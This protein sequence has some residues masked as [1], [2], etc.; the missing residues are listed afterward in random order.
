MLDRAKDVLRAGVDGLLHGI[1]DKP[2]DRELIDLIIRNRAVYV[3]T[4]SMYEAV[5]DIASW[6]KRQS[7]YD[8]R[9]ILFPLSDTFAAADLRPATPSRCSTTPPLPGAVCR[10]ESESQGGVRRR[11]AGRHG[12]RFGLPWRPDGGFEPAGAGADGRGRP[13]AGCGPSGGNDQRRADDR[14]RQGRGSIE[15]G[16]WRISSCSTR[17][18]WKTFA[19]PAAFT[20]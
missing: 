8:E 14:A 12:N 9:G 19:T 10:S 1:V 18:R 15:P 16:R 20:A 7:A 5:G 17:T 4:M 3:P 11:G 6:A 2:V 13:D